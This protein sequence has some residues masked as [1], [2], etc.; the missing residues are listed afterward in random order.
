MRCHSADRRVGKQAGQSAKAHRRGN[1]IVLTA[2]LM[3]AMMGMLAL[4]VDIGYVYTMQAQLQRSVDAAA[5]AGAAELVEGV[6]EA[7]AKATEYLV[8]NPVG[9]TMTVIDESALSG[10]ISQFEADHGDDLEVKFGNWNPNTRSFEETDVLPSS[11]NVVMAYQNLPLFFG[12]VLGHDSVTIR[13]ESTAMFQPRDIM[14]VLDFSASMNDDSEFTAFS[15]LG[16]AEVEGNLADIYSDLG[17]PNYGSVLQFA[18]QWA[19]AHGIPQNNG[20]GIPHVAVEYRYNQVHVASTSILTT[21]KL[22]FSNGNTQ[23]W[24]SASALTGTYQGSGTN[25]GKQIRKVWVKSWNNAA[26][27]GTN[28]EYFNFTSSGINSTLK[29]ALGLSGVSYPYAG[30]SWDGYIDWCESSSVQN[31]DAGYRYKFGYMNLI[32]YWLENYPEFNKCDDLWQVRAEPMQALK[33]SVGVFMD[34]IQAVDTNDRVGLAVYNA[35][36]GEG[37]VEVNLTNSLDQI[38]TLVN[39][40]QAGHHHQYTNIGGGLH[41]AREHLDSH[42]RAN[43]K[44]LIVL[45]TDGQANWRNGQYNET[46]ANNYVTEEAAICAQDSRKYQIFAISMGASADSSIMQQ[47]ASISEGAHFNVP[48]GSSQADYYQQL[49]DTFEEIA[50]ARP[51]KLV[52]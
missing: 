32:V 16:Q 2:F 44:K 35:P 7:Q 28:G 37:L 23:S 3:V 30:G 9:S 27:F 21:V 12:R 13:A 40:R 49:Y 42:G 20:A 52:K 29:T 5:L 25:S 1:V 24:N 14:L 36:N 51:L 18:P 48:G 31:D 45:M 6:D 22:E 43:A 33:S 50:K 15:K 11:L 19:V 17:S 38:P 47:A 8:R 34:F 39:Q 26:T 46:A 4:A 10:N 41:A